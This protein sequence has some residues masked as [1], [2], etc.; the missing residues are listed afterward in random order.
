[1]NGFLSYLCGGRAAY[2]LTKRA[3]RFFFFSW[4]PHAVCRNAAVF[5]CGGCV[6]G[7]LDAGISHFLVA[8]HR[9]DTRLESPTDPDNIAL[10]TFELVHLLYRNQV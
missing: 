6:E 8:K 1:M 5:L 9:E 3:V 10:L 4:L 2:I 7:S